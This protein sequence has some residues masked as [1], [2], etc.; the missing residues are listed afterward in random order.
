M[1][2]KSRL[3]KCLDKGGSWKKVK[4]KTEH[5]FM[6]VPRL[7]E[8]GPKCPPILSETQKKEGDQEK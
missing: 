4:I 7:W 3:R 1:K 2:I 6:V 8:M 5:R